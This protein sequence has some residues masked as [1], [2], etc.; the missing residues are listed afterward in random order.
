[1]QV[2][3]SGLVPPHKH[4]PAWIVESKPGLFLDQGILSDGPGGQNGPD[5]FGI[6][7]AGDAARVV[8]AGERTAVVRPVGRLGRSDPD[9]GRSFGAVAERSAA[10]QSQPDHR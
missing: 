9:H 6:E 7:P 2:G 10:Y 4:E 8:V 5:L 3:D 1:M